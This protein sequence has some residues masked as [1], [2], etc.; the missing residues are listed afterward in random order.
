MATLLGEWQFIDTLTAPP[1]TG[2]I[3]LN[4][5]AQ[6]TA[7][8]LWVNRTTATGANATAVLQ[9]ILQGQDIRLDNKTDA[10]KWQTY[11]VTGPPVTVTTH[12][13]Y[14][15][16]WKAGGGA[17]T[18][19]RSLLYSLP[20]G[21]VSV[22]LEPHH[23]L[24]AHVGNV[25]ITGQ[26]VIRDFAFPF[27]GK[28]YTN[29]GLSIRQWYAGQAMVGFLSG[30]AVNANLIGTLATYAFKVADSMIA[31]EEAE[32]DGTPQPIVGAAKR[33]TI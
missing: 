15:V 1:S 12:L 18:Q 16:A 14:P 31:F 2:L 4:Q 11:T 29:T 7:T 20:A 28:T 13:E 30:K 25:D 17:I 8:K 33:K 9:G 32:S 24:E 21:N 19:Q 23:S 6:A 27:Q 22:P 5:V 3:R 10:S 26:L